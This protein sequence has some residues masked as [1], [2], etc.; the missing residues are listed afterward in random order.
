[1]AV[2]VAVAVCSGGGSGYYCPGA[3][4]AVASNGGG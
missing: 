4:V 1:M 2:A 3:I